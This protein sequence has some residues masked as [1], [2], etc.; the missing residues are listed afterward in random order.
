LTGIVRAVLDTNVVLSALLWGG[1]P[2]ALIEAAADSQIDLF[3]TEQ[4]V[5][6]LSSSLSKPRLAPQVAAT[7]V[8]VA[9]HLA[10]YRAIARVIDADPVPPFVS[11]DRDDDHVIAAAVTAQAQL[12]VTGDADL[13]VLE[14]FQTC[15]IITINEALDVIRE[16]SSNHLSR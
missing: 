15:L 14:R 16:T 6:E 5:E 1:K 10:N 4:L 8:S 13:L 11:R 7:W 3:T 2:L 9:D 12:L